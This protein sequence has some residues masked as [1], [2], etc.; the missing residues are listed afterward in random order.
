[1]ITWQYMAMCGTCSISS[2]RTLGS[3]KKYQI[4]NYVQ[5]N[6]EI[7]MSKNGKMQKSEFLTVRFLA[8]LDFRRLG[9]MVHTKSVQKLNAFGSGFKALFVQ[10]R[11]NFVQKMSEI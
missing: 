5:W 3:V 11:N 7:Q 6:A 2:D 10:K 8:R 9:L 1:M 4:F